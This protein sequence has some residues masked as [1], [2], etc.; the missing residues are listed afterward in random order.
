MAWVF[1]LVLFPVAAQLYEEPGSAFPTPT[2]ESNC[3]QDNLADNQVYYQKLDQMFNGSSDAICPKT[4][5]LF[6]N[7][8]CTWAAGK[9]TMT[10]A[11]VINQCH[12]AIRNFHWHDSSD[13]WSYMVQGVM[14]VIL[15]SPTG[16]PWHSAVN[17]IGPGGVAANTGTFFTRVDPAKFTWLPEENAEPAAVNRSDVEVEDTTPGVGQGIQ[18]FNI[19]TA[20]FPFATRMSQQRI[21][22]Q[23]GGFRNL[24]WITNAAA[25]MTVISGHVNA[26]TQG[27]ISGG[28]DQGPS[29][30]SYVAKSLGPY[31]AF[32]FPIRR[33]YWIEEATGTE[34][35]E[36]IV[37]FEVG[38]W[39]ALEAKTGF[40]CS[41]PVGA[42]WAYEATAG[43]IECPSSPELIQRRNLRRHEPDAQS[44]M[45]Q[46]AENPEL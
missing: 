9:A 12:W 14:Q 39:K 26:A 27:G 42:P 44:F 6:V 37:V 28:F 13:E 4:L 8:P 5:G 24:V 33:G 31:D 21:V 3:F 30:K 18:V 2:V 34:P 1:S 23:P 38:N 20:Q 15:T 43:G 46:P 25:T 19:R 40:G 11:P 35:A 22:F 10:V 41:N 16:V 17:T 29:S 32:Y 36:V 45:Q 7:K